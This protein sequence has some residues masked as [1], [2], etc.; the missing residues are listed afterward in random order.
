MRDFSAGKGTGTGTGNSG[1]AVLKGTGPAT[2]KVDA[3]TAFVV[4]DGLTVM[5]D[6][7]LDALLTD[8]RRTQLEEHF[9]HTRKPDDASSLARF[10]REL[11]DGTYH[12]PQNF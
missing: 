3:Q 7:V 11:I 9:E 2:T 8:Y 4:S 6:A 12:N 5:L 1:T 10:T